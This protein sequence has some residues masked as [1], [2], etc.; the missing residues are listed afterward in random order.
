[1]S[2]SSN[3]TNITTNTDSFFEKRIKENNNTY[4]SASFYWCD[5][6]INIDPTIKEAEHEAQER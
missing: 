6:E 4:T 3:N 5:C 1:M 2:N